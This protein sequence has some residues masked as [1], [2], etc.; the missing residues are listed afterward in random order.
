MP[1]PKQSQD[2]DIEN[3]WDEYLRCLDDNEMPDDEKA[4]RKLFTAGWQAKAED[5]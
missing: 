2:Q 5:K 3:A 4:A 1:L